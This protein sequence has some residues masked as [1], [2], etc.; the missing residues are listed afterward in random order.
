MKCL[1]C[2]PGSRGMIRWSLD[3]LVVNMAVYLYINKSRR[4]Q[5][6]SRSPTRFFSVRQ[7]SPPLQ[8]AFAE[9]L[10]RCHAAA[11]RLYPLYQQSSAKLERFHAQFEARRT[12]TLAPSAMAT[13]VRICQTP[14]LVYLLAAGSWV[15]P[16]FVTSTKLRAIPVKF[17]LES[18]KRLRTLPL[19]ISPLAAGFLVKTGRITKFSALLC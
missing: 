17:R 7:N 1:G 18:A 16:P 19:A 8:A 11:I 3:F 2:R 6:E 10:S 13:I 9:S 15:A 4:N 14:S 5:T 12:R